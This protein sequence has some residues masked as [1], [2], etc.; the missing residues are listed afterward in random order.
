MLGLSVI[1][2]L[3]CM[4]A[5]GLTVTPTFLNTK[6]VIV[7]LSRLA[8]MC[9]QQYLLSCLLAVH[10]T[11]VF[12]LHSFSLLHSC[13]FLFQTLLLPLLL[14]LCA[15]PVQVANSPAV[16]LESRMGVIQVPALGHAWQLPEVIKSYVSLLS[17]S[18]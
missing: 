14:A 16:A 18:W 1:P 7:E 13:C 4:S 5:S 6:A 9:L 10:V 11:L 12:L 3:S 17:K 15:E 2:C 8:L